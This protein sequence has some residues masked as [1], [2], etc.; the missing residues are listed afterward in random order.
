MS[1]YAFVAERAKKAFASVAALESALVDRPQDRALLINLASMRRFADQARAELER[2]AEVNHIEICRYRLVPGA[3]GEYGLGHVAKSLISYQYLFTQIYDAFKNG[4]KTKATFGREAEQESMFDFAYSYSGSL[5][6][7]LLARSSRDFI[8]GNL[9]KPIEALYRIMDVSDV[10]SVR[11]IAAELGR[12]VVKRV[13]DWSK[14]NV[15]GDFSPDIQ[16][17]RSDGKL[18]GQ[19]IDRNRLE[20]IVEF[21]DSTAD[22]KTTPVNARGMFV[23]GNVASR[24]FHI[25]IPEGETYIGHI[26]SQAELPREIILGRMYDAVIE[27]SEIYYYATEVTTK[28]NTLI[29]LTGPLTE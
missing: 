26:S 16:W 3:G 23:G 15:E 8:D 4:I 10:D 7:V 21:I 1:D 25:S 28:T 2:L 20:A 6:V 22:E 27:V 17:R 24:S 13:H 18:L 14:A 5:G 12:A 19:M 11:S 9:D 29:R